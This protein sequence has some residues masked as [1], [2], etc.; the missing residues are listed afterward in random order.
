M[1]ECPILVG[2]FERF[3]WI[4]CVG[5]GSFLT[6]PI[7]KS[8]GDERIAHGE[9]CLVVDLGACTGMDSTFMGTL[10]GLAAR[11]SVAENG[12]LQVAD[13][14]ERNRRSLEDLGLDFLIEIDPPAAD[15]RGRV[16]EVR[17]NLKPCRGGADQG[18]QARHVLEAHQV[19]SQTNDS[20][21]RKFATVVDL[22]EEELAEKPARN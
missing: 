22:L 11:L 18:S 14:G 1:T 8:F 13:P 7:M 5:K 15:W 21:A 12:V 9:R 20:N 4:R 19:L 17:M 3:S 10:A 6:S 16:D 2:T